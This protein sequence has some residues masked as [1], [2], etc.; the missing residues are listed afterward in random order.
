MRSTATTPRGRTRRPRGVTDEDGVFF[1]GRWTLGI[2][3]DA[4]FSNPVHPDD[5]EAV[6]AAL[7]RRCEAAF[8][9][10]KGD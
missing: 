6:L 5:A 2:P 4:G 8:R 7:R 3:S 10:R 1:F 9:V